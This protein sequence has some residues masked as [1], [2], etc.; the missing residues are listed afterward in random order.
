MD[1]TP[2]RWLESTQLKVAAIDQKIFI[3]Y[4]YPIVKQHVQEVEWS[5]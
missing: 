5:R 2:N 1:E 4:S 3:I